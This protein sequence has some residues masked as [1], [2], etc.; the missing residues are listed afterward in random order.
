MIIE[1][2]FMASEISARK[3]EIKKMLLT[4]LVMVTYVHDK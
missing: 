2:K 1:W 3:K 4:H